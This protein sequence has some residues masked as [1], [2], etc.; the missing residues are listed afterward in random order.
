MHAG[1]SM[2]D[3]HQSLS[4]SYIGIEISGYH[5][6]EPTDKQKQA[7]TLLVADLQR[8]Y[9]LGDEDVLTHSMVAYGN[10]NQWHNY[11]HRGRKRCGML[12]ATEDLRLE[13]GLEN[14]FSI[15][16]DVKAGRLKNADDY[17]ASVL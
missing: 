16:P 1:R 10:P 14:T 6:K 17:L 5:D 3:N 8:I 4:L 9:N 13:I 11:S 7:L 15:D 12:Y 2:W